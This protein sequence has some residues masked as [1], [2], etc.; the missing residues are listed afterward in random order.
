MILSILDT[1]GKARKK[2]TRKTIGS[3][4]ILTL[5]AIAVNF[6]Y[7]IFG[8]GV[9]STAMTWMFLY[10][11]LGGALI[12]LLIDRRASGITR[13]SGYRLGFNSYNSGIATLTI[14]S[15]IKGVLDI[16]GTNSP[17]LVFYTGM[18]WLF[19][20]IGMTIFIILVV[21]RQKIHAMIKDTHEY[22]SIIE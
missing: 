9:H 15:F 4:L 22:K 14:G 6:V 11:L 5:T 3:Y 10:P 18:G 19:I 13:F 17:Y 20:A 2:K 21:N 12:Y 8:H 16:A 1:K 7:G